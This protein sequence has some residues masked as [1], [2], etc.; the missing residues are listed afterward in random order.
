MTS[1][2][3]VIATLELDYYE[4]EVLMYV[5]TYAQAHCDMITAPRK[6]ALN[7]LANRLADTPCG[8]PG[9]HIC[10]DPSIYE[11]YNK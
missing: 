11:E 9:C 8:D 6:N 5:L 10:G 7:R 3:D 1:K 4:R 2:T